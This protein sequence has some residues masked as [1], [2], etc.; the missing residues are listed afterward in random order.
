MFIRE[1]HFGFGIETEHCLVD[2]NTLKPLFHNELKFEQLLHIMDSIYVDDFSTN[3]FNIKPLHRR[4]SPYLVEGYYITD[5]KMEPV[6][7]LPKGVEVRTPIASTVD[8]AINDLQILTE[9][10]RDAFANSGMLLCSISHHPLQT[11]FQAKPNYKRHDHWQWALTAMTTY[12]PDV[13][14]SLPR[15]LEN[16]VELD[17]LHE[18]VNYYMP[19]V[20]ALTFC[21]P[22]LKGKLW[23]VGG[24]L[25][26]S[27]RT[28]RRSVWAPLLYVHSG[29]SSRFEF[30]GFEM[31]L[32]IDD[33][34]VFFLCALSLLLDD[35]LDGRA[36]D[37]DRIQRL[38]R[39][40]L[41]GVRHNKIELER[42]EQ[43]LTS[44]QR[45]AA[46][47]DAN[48]SC[49]NEFWNRWETGNS[50][51]DRIIDLFKECGTVEKTMSH[52]IVPPL[53]ADST[54]ELD[55]DAQ[56]DAA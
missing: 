45:M 5:D 51:A 16:Q 33:Y 10:I 34:K 42:A 35:A 40:A 38:R 7:M 46:I 12:G 2:A 50:P 31:P 29:D 41:Y 39:L 21:S 22:L 47:F 11:D 54:A 37:E 25:G 36:S 17:S 48:A 6:K 4:A 55:D 20:I 56:P 13:S 19:S 23:Q 49:F 52:L 3:G 27:V 44:A 26:K 43:L 15:N 30:K 8:G 32:D 9:R 24:K 28:F 53:Y 18:K 14:I 1:K